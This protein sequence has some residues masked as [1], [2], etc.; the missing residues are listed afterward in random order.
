MYTFT[1][2]D[3]AVIAHELWVTRSKF[4][5]VRIN[6]YKAMPRLDQ[7][8]TEKNFQSFVDVPVVPSE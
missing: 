3:T 8:I 5:T 2:S 1:L 7:Q 4:E 6:V